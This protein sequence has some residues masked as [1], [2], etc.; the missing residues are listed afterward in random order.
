MKHNFKTKSVHSVF[1]KKFKKAS[2]EIAYNDASFLLDVAY[3]ITKARNAM[4][5]SQGDLA[6]KL[7]TS[8]SVISRIENGNQNL[9]IMM[10]RKIA[11]TL[12]C[13]ISFTLKQSSKNIDDASYNWGLKSESDYT[14]YDK[15]INRDP[16]NSETMEVK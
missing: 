6:R 2:Y 15:L 4:S 7:H 13:S 8:Q 16:S 12:G 10:L 11:L 1:D 5:L 9:S 3:E 14:K